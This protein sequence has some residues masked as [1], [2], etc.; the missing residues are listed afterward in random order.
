[1]SNKEEMIEYIK[2]LADTVRLQIVGLLVEGPKSVTEIST[3]LGMS[4]AEMTR[5]LEILGASGILRMVDDKYAL[6]EAAVEAFRVEQLHR[7]RQFFTPPDW[8]SEEDGKII[9]KLAAP[10]GSLKRLPNQLKHWM[11]VLRYVLPNFEPGQSYT[12]KQVNGLL[13]RYHHDTAV[14]RRFLVDTGM[15]NRE[16]DGSRY[17]CEVRHEQ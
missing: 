10:D 11:A 8:L 13:M 7:P 5:P 17:W 16:R 12:E 15:L 1:M 2:S 9:R 14:L 3:S 4:P 6:D